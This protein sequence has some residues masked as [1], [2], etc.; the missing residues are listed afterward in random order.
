MIVPNFFYTESTNRWRRWHLTKS[1]LRNK[2]NF[3]K[4]HLKIA[5]NGLWRCQIEIYGLRNFWNKEDWSI[6]SQKIPQYTYQRLIYC[7]IIILTTMIYSYKIIRKKS[8]SIKVIDNEKIFI[9]LPNNFCKKKLINLYPVYCIFSR[10]KLIILTNNC[11][12]FSFF[13]PLIMC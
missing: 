7:S 4:F 5:Y 8:I 10:W 12:N 1:L 13:F 9:V 11:S 3:A 2:I 6:T